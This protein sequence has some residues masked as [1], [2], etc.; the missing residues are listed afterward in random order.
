[1]PKRLVRKKQGRK[2]RSI[3]TR[4]SAAKRGYG[5]K[6]RLSREQFLKLNPICVM[7]K[8]ENRVNTATV[9]DHITPHKGDK[10]LF[11]DRENWQALCES[12]H[13]A[14]SAKEK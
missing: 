3:D 11:W 13:N 8:D 9:V 1:M 4:L 2:K 14:K 7:C 12:H 5:Y 6:W 10:E